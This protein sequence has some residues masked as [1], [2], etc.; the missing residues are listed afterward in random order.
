[1]L[2]A[3]TLCAS[4]LPLQEIKMK[5][6]KLA[7]VAAALF[8]ASSAANA[9]ATFDSVK[10]KGFVQCGVSTGIPGFSMADSK[11]EWKGIDVAMSRAIAA[12]MFNDSTKFK[13]TPL[14]T[15]QLFTALQ[16][17]EFDVLTRTPTHP[18]PRPSTLALSP[19]ADP[20]PPPFISPV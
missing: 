8:A 16:S 17:A 13:V 6:L 5:A 20:C 1:M 11:G 10:K 12:T 4:R 3:P 18:L 7:A 15:Q 14:N 19:P 2:D 9:G